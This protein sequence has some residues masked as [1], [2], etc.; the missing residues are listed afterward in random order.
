MKLK[1]FFTALI[2]TISSFSPVVAQE[3]GDTV[4]EFSKKVINANPIDQIQAAS[5]LIPLY[6]DMV[7]TVNGKGTIYGNRA[8]CVSEVML[9]YLSQLVAETAPHAQF[10]DNN[11]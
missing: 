10:V 8:I 1:R 7:T 9:K 6:C 4:P 5:R 2:L 3:T 11:K